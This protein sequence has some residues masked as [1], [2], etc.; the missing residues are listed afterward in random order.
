MSRASLPGVMNAEP[1]HLEQRW[2]LAV[3]ACAAPISSV[4]VAA[5]FSRSVGELLPSV[6]APDYPAWQNHRQFANASRHLMTLESRTTRAVH[7]SAFLM[8]EFIQCLL[9]AIP[10]PRTAAPL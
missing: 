7:E 4:T 2:W 1:L 3:H 8:M 5:R 9:K 10:R 6:R